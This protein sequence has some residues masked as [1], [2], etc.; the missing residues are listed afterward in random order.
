MKSDVPSELRDPRQGTESAYAERHGVDLGRIAV[1]ASVSF[2]GKLTGTGLRYL[3]QVAIALF[4]GANLF[5]IYAL[6]IAIYQFGELLA[7]M[8]L[9]SGVVRYA[10]IHHGGRDGSR[11]LG[12]L[13]QST[14]LPFLGGLIVGLAIF[15]LAD[16]IALRWF[17]KPPV[18]VVLRIVAVALPFGASMIVTALATTGF[19]VTRYLVYIRE[20]VHPALNLLFVILLCSLGLGIIGASIAW[21][22]AAVVG[23]SVALYVVRRLIP[24]AASGPVKPVYETGTL[25]AF[26]L[27]LLLGELS[28]L[29]LLWTDIIMLGSFRSAG[30][31]GVYRAASQTALFIPVFLGSINTI[32]A[33][34]IA[35]FHNKGDINSMK[36]SFQTS[37]RWS[38]L[39]SVPLF[40]VMVVAGEELLRVFGSAF[41]VGSLP[42]VVLGMGQLV[43]AGSGG[44]GYM[45][46][47]SGHQYLKLAGDLV[48][49]VVNIVL[50]AL[51]IPTWGLMGAAV[52]TGISIAGLN[53]LRGLQVYRI[54]G[55]QA[56]AVSYVKI[57]VAGLVAVLGGM[58]V[59]QLAFRAH[60]LFT[61]LASVLAIAVLY[62][63]A[64]WA[65]RF[66]EADRLVFR[67]ARERFV[68]H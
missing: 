5:G 34:M 15:M 4:L 64:L 12:V 38:L 19:Q 63:L 27:P 9:G 51:L 58:F 6:G 41:V 49:A 66:E 61:L 52:A 35:D 20:L 53:V 44:V 2:L 16:T 11:L 10:A 45:L 55:V 8:G 43:N 7:A 46:I 57:A 67:Q 14:R 22:I 36:A 3:S 37:T 29:L 24:S 56:Y 17:D 25:L 48:F 18:A 40:L 28:W 31:V 23:L 21:V 13:K 68:R 30:D 32:F 1:G 50:N 33:P 54:L 39:L 47:M 59:H 42:L 62:G 65:L 26:S 60:F